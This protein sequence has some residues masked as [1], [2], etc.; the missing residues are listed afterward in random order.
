MSMT[1]TAGIKPYITQELRSALPCPTLQHH[2][3]DHIISPSPA[4]C[5]NL[6]IG[7]LPA[8]TCQ[9]ATEHE[10]LTTHC[11][12]PR[13]RSASGKRTCSELPRSCCWS[14]HD[15]TR[16]ATPLSDEGK[17][18]ASKS[19]PRTQ[20]LLRDILHAISERSLR[21]N[22]FVS[23][24]NK[25][26]Q[27][28]YAVSLSAERPRHRHAKSGAIETLQHVGRGQTRFDMFDD[29]IIPRTRPLSHSDDG[30]I[31]RLLMLTI[32]T[33]LRNV[34]H[35]WPL[36]LIFKYLLLFYLHLEPYTELNYS[37]IQYLL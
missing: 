13:F 12:T 14:P 32:W 6:L 17:Q 24:Q 19:S 25:N 3:K 7:S 5:G 8:S 33:H 26:K 16:P 31:D 27:A 23:R 18:A 4:S 10:E 29:V 37:I 2:F 36:E 15:W 9:E 20:R 28:V 30:L 22:E 11:H 1:R 34:G 21:R 35:F